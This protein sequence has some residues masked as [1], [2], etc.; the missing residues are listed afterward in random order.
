ME[1]SGDEKS[2]ADG[3][4]WRIGLANCFDLRFPEMSNLLSFPP[5][6]GVGAELIMYP[7]SWLKSTGDM[8]HWETLLKARALDCQC[9]IMGV[10]NTY[11]PHQDSRAF[12]RSC[13]VG[14][15]GE[16]LAVC[17]DDSADEIVHA[18]LK[19]DKLID[20]RKRI[21]LADCRRPLVYEKALRSVQSNPFAMM[22][23]PPGYKESAANGRDSD[24]S[25]IN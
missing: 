19:L 1:D 12:G 23:P 20:A 5:P 16:T 24:I 15:L 10:S 22:R 8:G 4:G 18:S 13:V 6:K 2:G 21:P 14:P 11:D 17:R 25:D 7:S 3:R 9:F